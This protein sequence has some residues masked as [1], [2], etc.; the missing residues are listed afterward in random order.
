MR[1]NYSVDPSEK[2]LAQVSEAKL[3]CA[4]L[5]F[6]PYTCGVEVFFS[7]KLKKYIAGARPSDF[8][9][10]LRWSVSIPY[11]QLNLKNTRFTWRWWSAIFLMMLTRGYNNEGTLIPSRI[12]IVLVIKST[13]ICGPCSKVLLKVIDGWRSVRK[14]NKC[15]AQ[16][17]IK[18]K[19]LPPIT[20]LAWAVVSRDPVTPNTYLLISADLPTFESPNTMICV[21]VNA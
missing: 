17:S 1:L 5:R 11:L 18:Y 2:T 9:G 13:P 19:I 12:L 3:K 15:K 20:Y 16:W 6:V 10:H 21:S 4:C 14:R 7:R 8:N